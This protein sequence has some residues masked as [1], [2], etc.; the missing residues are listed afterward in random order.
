MITLYGFG[1]FSGLPDASPFVLKVMC[2]LKFAGL[3][4]REDRSSYARAPKGKL[5]YIDDDGTI[6]A[7]ST[8]IR[9][10]IEKT[11]QIDFDAHLTPE[12]RATAWAV[13]R[14]CEDHLYWLMA[15]ERWI[16]DGNFALGPAEFFKAVPAPL[17]PIAEWMARRGIAKRLHLQGAG[18]YSVEEA[19]QLGWRAM[20][21]P[22]TLLGGNSFL[23][24]DA[25]CGADATL[26]A[27]VAGIFLWPA[28]RSRLRE[29]ASSHANL[30]AYRDRIM[31][32]Y[33]PSFAAARTA[34]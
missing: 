24:G 10:H 18:R 27:F 15:R 3:D 2:L 8:L 19:A 21:T 5:P 28:A 25:P 23:F 20:E 16:D 12:Q 11:R 30:V 7:D 1:P 17:R 29:A 22:A 33:F 34:L 32:R 31:N 4:Y 13:E 26:F 6:V 9:W 14:M